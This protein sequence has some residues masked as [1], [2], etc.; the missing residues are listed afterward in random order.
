MEVL[1]KAKEG[2]RDQQINKLR[3]EVD[4]YKQNIFKF[5]QQRFV[6]EEMDTDTY[7]RL[8]N[9][10]NEQIDRLT[11]Q[12]NDLEVTDTSFEKYTRYG[13]SL[14]KDLSWYFQEAEPQAKRKLL[15][16][17]FP[18]KLV[19]QDGNYR[20]T[21][22]NLALALILQKNRGLKNEKAED[23]IIPENVSGDVERSGIEPL[24]STMPLLRSTN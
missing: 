9:H 19:F 24:T 15:G 23:M 11:I 20:T 16:S 13:I 6:S 10:A 4:R 3:T 14:L 2:D 21:A 18:A 5:D 8:K 17:I 1:F 12:I 7:K 22:L